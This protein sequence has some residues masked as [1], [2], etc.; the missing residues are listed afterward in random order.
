MSSELKEQADNSCGGKLI[1]SSMHCFSAD[2]LAGC[3]KFSELAN[4]SE[5][6]Q[7]VIIFN[8]SCIINAAS[9]L[10]AKIN[11]E[12]SIAVI[13]H[14]EGGPEGEAWR[15]VQ[16][17]QKKLNVQEKW[18]LVALRTN[19]IEWNNAVEP[20]QSIELIISLRNE[21]VHY[22]GAFFGRDEA[23]NKKI[24]G[25]MKQLGI[26]SKATW[27]DDDCSSWIADLLSTK[28]ISEWVYKSIARFSNSYYELRNPKY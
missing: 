26:S 21:L 4:T 22:K 19:G 15:A 20:F 3:K 23:P 16:N 10:E 8:T 13:C 11:E 5:K 7:D 17:L 28:E 12:I 2:F 6:S 25:L 27:L 14:D 9:Y 1:K 18:D 24:K